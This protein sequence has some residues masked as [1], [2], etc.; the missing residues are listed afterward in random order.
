M[1]QENYAASIVSLIH[2]ILVE[3]EKNNTQASKIMEDFKSFI[4]QIMDERDASKMKSS[5]I[6]SDEDLLTREQAAQL[7]SVTKL[8]IDRWARY[9]LIRRKYVGKQVRYSKKELMEN[10]IVKY[11][12]K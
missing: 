6:E 7:C 3:R 2:Q 5:K 9:Q 12:R 1:K 8:T 4:Y 11:K 10:E